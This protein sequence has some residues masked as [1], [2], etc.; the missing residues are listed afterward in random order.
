MRAADAA[1]SRD[2]VVSVYHGSINDA[3]QIR[4]H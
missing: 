1:T 3:T 4:A 2:D